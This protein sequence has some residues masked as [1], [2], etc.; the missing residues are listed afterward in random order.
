MDAPVITPGDVQ[1]ERIGKHAVHQL[2]SLFP[3]LIDEYKVLVESNK[4]SGQN[5]AIIAD[6]YSSLPM[7]AIA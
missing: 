2:A 7:V 1:K 6:Q 5:L 4:V 3:L